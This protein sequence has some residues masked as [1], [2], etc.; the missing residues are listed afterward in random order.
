VNGKNSENSG[1]YL[2]SRS[3]KLQRHATRFACI[4][5][6][7]TK[8]RPHATQVTYSSLSHTT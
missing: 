2:A 5:P 3:G 7:L 1:Y 4:E 6:R 8:V